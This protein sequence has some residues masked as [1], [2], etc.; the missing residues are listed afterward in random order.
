MVLRAVTS[1]DMY[2]LFQWVNDPD[3]RVSST[4]GELITWDQHVTWFLNMLNSQNHWAYI[5]QKNNEPCG[6]IRFQSSNGE[7]TLSYSIAPQFRGLGLSKILLELGLKMFAG[8]S[9]NHKVSGLISK[10]N[11]KSQKA[12]LRVGFKEVGNVTVGKR[13]F[14]KYCLT[15]V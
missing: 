6:I 1:D 7:N 2:L 11:T 15:I 10:E 14:K 12:F 3:S 5:L 4:S 9:G 13:I 8:E